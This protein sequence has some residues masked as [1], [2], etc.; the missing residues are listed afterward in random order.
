MI[1]CSEFVLESACVMLH[2]ADC[3]KFY[4]N[5]TVISENQPDMQKCNVCLQDNSHGSRSP[6][7]A[8]ES[9]YQTYQHAV[10]HFDDDQICFRL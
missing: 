10:S 5:R 6:S 4:R 2:L 3:F 8:I 7:T 9:A 1:H